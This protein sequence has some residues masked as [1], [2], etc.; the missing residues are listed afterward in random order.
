MQS[1]TW[2]AEV[3]PWAFQTSACGSLGVHA[4]TCGREIVEKLA[5]FMEGS[6]GGDIVR[7]LEVLI[8]TDQVAEA[9]ANVVI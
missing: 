9:A 1:Q 4:I 6:R 3:T 2:I 7:E 8:G 5:L